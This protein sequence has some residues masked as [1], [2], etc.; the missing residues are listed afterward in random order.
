MHHSLR[1]IILVVIVLLMIAGL[2][3]IIPSFKYTGQAIA[4]NEYSAKLGDV[5]SYNVAFDLSLSEVSNASTPVLIS[6]G[7]DGKIID[8]KIIRFDEL[9]SFTNSS[10]LEDRVYYSFNAGK[11]I[12]YKFDKKG[13]Y[14]LYFAVLKFDIIDNTKIIVE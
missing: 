4:N 13:E 12:N 7:N 14:E 5:L 10:V 8:S 2:F 6:L 9:L 11:I 3:F 1:E